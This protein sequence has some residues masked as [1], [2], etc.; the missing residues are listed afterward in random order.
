MYIF[1]N[2]YLNIVRTKGRN[3]LIGIIIT[4]ITLGSCIAI[5]INKSGH[6]LVETYKNTNPLEVTLSIDT[7]SYRN[8]SDDVKNN[9][10]LLTVDKIEE[11]GSL[12]EVEGYYYTLQSYLNS[13]DITAIDYEKLFTKPDD[14]KEES[15]NMK[16]PDDKNKMVSSGDYNIIAYSDISYNEDFI[17][18]KRKITEG[19]MITKDNTAM[20]IVI[21]EELA[22]ENDLS[23]GDIITFTNTSN[24][25]ITYELEI[26]GIYEI[27][28]DTSINNPGGRGMM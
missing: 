15:N 14:L 19:A 28:N 10:Q 18:G 4:V 5:T 7:M 9:F 1:K 12:E 24:E 13:D 17:S 16:M 23:V 3:L 11:I 6:N 20:Q 21:S 8:A 25:D 2:A 27:V 22:S 26:I